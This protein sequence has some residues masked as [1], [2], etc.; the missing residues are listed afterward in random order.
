ME[1]NRF[2][3]EKIYCNENDLDNTVFRDWTNLEQL[4]GYKVPYHIFAAIQQNVEKPQKPF[5]QLNRKEKNALRN[6]VFAY[7][8]KNNMLIF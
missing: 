3:D 1:D 4:L 6:R 5:A 7:L 2:T 8:K